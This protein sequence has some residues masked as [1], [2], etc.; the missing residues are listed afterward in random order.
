MKKRI[1]LILTTVILAVAICLTGMPEICAYAATVTVTDPDSCRIRKEPSTSSE[2]I[3][4]VKSGKV[5][6]VVGE[7]TGTDGYTWYQ[8]KV[9][10]TTTGYIRA[11]LVS[12]PDGNISS[13]SSASTSSSSSTT[14]DTSKKSETASTS[15]EKKSETAAST[16][17]KSDTAGEVV[18]SDALTATVTADTVTVRENASTKSNKVGT[19]KNGQD[20]FINGEAA[21]SEGKTWYKINFEADGKT[22]DGFI[23]S[24]F[25][26]ITSTTADLAPEEPESVE[27]EPE[28]EPVVNT[29][30]EVRYEA[31][32][33]GIEEWFLYDHINGNKQSIN[34]IKAV[35]EQS[36]NMVVDDGSEVKTMKIVIIVMAVI[37]LLLII[38]VAILLFRLRDRYEDFDDIEDE[39]YDD[40]EE[41]EEEI[42]EMDEE[43]EYESKRPAKKERKFGFKSRR[44]NYEDNEEEDE[45][46]EEEEDEEPE[47]YTRPVRRSTPAQPQSRRSTEESWSSKSL[48]DIDDDMEF[49]FLDLDN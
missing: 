13:S 12:T 49:E 2:A 35:M 25:L 20:L 38:A 8:V 23:R 3:S 21:D 36:Q 33:E 11:D 4:S 34:N 19:A 16:E 37:M 32:A 29:D 9:E 22:V 28:P 7:A 14:S 15:T 17:S 40:E 43:E 42:E 47:V 46:E 26:E 1:K 5:L 44:K 31:N 6:E 18:D 39:D 24:D 41:D 45:E 30:Y 48:M 27:P 10:G